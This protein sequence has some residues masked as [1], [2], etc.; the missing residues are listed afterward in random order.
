MYIYPTVFW[1]DIKNFTITLPDKTNV[2]PLYP[3]V[4]DTKPQEI[5]NRLTQRDFWPISTEE[6]KGVSYRPQTQ[7]NQEC[8]A[9]PMQHLR[10][11]PFP[12]KGCYKCQ[13]KESSAWRQ[14]KDLAYLC[15]NCY[16]IE[17][18]KRNAPS[19]ARYQGN[20]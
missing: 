20:N 17:Y 15:N 7:A 10:P 4:L 1:G 12:I 6:K 2:I 9:N 14:I 19:K 13:K 18:H 5:S 3:L 11:P 16:W 8:Y